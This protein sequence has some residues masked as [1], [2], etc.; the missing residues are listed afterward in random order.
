MTS[1]RWLPA[2]FCT[3]TSRCTS[4]VSISLSFAGSTNKRRLPFSFSGLVYILMCCHSL[5][6]SSCDCGHTFLPYMLW[7]TVTM[8]PPVISMPSVNNE[9]RRRI[10][11]ATSEPRLMPTNRI[12]LLSSL[13]FAPAKSF[14]RK[15]K[16]GYIIA[17]TTKHC[18]K[19][20]RLPDAATKATHYERFFFS[21]CF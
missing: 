3:L 4:C 1:I 9:E 15:I 8:S 19:P 20:S 16:C 5:A 17:I 21:W 13:A 18:N 7:A 12:G 11:S 2:S 10:F 6:N 14:L